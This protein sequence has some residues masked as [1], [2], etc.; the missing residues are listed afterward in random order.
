MQDDA[1]IAKRKSDHISINLNQDVRS[2]QS[3]GFENYHFRHEAVPEISLDQVDTSTLFFGKRLVA[4][5]LI[6]SMTGG[7]VHT[8][9]LNEILATAAEK[10]QIAIGLG[11]QR[12]A[13]RHP[14][15]RPSFQIRKFAPTTLLF[16]N[17]GAGQLNDGFGIDECKL[18]VEMI[19][20]D[21]LIFHFNTLMEAVQPEGNTDFSGLL[22]KLEKICANL[23][24]P[25]IAK[26]VGWGIDYKTAKR[27]AD[28]GVACIDVAGA[29][30]T[31]WSEVEAYRN[32]GIHKTV[33]HSF[34]GWG[35][36]TAYCLESIANSDLDVPLIAS[37]GLDNG[38]DLAK[39]L[40]LGAALGGFARK[41]LYAAD[42]SYDNLIEVLTE[43]EL[44]LKYTM[45]A[46]GIKNINEFDHSLFR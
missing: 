44:E 21:A 13:I 46:C 11:S 4:P 14:E 38:I 2:T 40:A 28:A 30:G 31:S 45:F 29:G 39:S 41:L 17:L 12:V 27:L 23:G 24:V 6:S 35:M 36:P 20:A 43:I 10:M 33:A 42:Q 1:K 22:P 5:I 16:A 26:E 18:A 3:A 37:G 34:R 32:T 8:R 25:V 9:Q 15:T 19:E 7:A